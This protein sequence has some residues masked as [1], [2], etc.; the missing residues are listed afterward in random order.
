MGGATQSS[1]KRHRLP[2]CKCVRMPISGAWM[3]PRPVVRVDIVHRYPATHGQLLQLAVTLIFETV[4]ACAKGG[5]VVDQAVPAEVVQVFGRSMLGQ[6][7]RAGTVDHGQLA[8]W[9]RYQAIVVDGA[10]A[11]HAIETF[12]QWVYAAVTAA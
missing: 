1:S 12:A 2:L 3:M 4:W 8:Q 6:I 11:Q 10:N 9:S 5:H 7:S